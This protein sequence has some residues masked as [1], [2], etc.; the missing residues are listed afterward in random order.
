[1]K[2]LTKIQTEFLRLA[3]LQQDINNAEHSSRKSVF[4]GGKTDPNDAW[5]EQIKN[6]LGDKFVFMDPYDDNWDPLDNIYDECNGLLKADY[7]VFYKGGKQSIKEQAFLSNFN[8]PYFTSN[9]IIEILEYLKKIKIKKNAA[10]FE[11]MTQNQQQQYLD[12]HPSSKKRIDQIGQ[13]IADKLSVTFNGKWP[14]Q[15]FFAFT[16]PQTKS[17]FVAK[18]LEQAEF[19]LHQMR[20]AFEKLKHAKIIQ[21]DANT[22][23]IKNALFEKSKN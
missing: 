16:D 21:S 20:K 23:L 7:I 19:R 3:N 10:L 8:K 6:S 5:R 17:T 11:E 12:D 2:H 22:Y 4:L 15:D 13:N 18:T 1:M 14:G 9:N